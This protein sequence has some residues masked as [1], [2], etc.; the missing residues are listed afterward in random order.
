MDSCAQLISLQCHVLSFLYPTSPLVQTERTVDP[1][2]IYNPVYSSIREEM[3]AT[4]YGRDYA[5][6][7]ERTAVWG[8]LNCVHMCVLCMCMCI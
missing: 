6:L 4:A 7:E 8:L 3:S 2:V 5:A 1:F